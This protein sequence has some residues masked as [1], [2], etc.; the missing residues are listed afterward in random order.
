MSLF[1]ALGHPLDGVL[2]LRFPKVDD[3]SEF[4][5]SMGINH[6]IRKHCL[7]LNLILMVDEIFVV[8]L[9]FFL[10]SGLTDNHILV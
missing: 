6:S 10:G 7:L 2:M 1:V 9:P 3:R 5:L 4:A 8:W